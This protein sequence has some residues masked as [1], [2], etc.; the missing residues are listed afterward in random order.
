MLEP[1]RPVERDLPAG[2]SHHYQFEMVAGQ[3]ARA[4]LDKTSGDFVLI[5]TGS[6]GRNIAE[7]KGAQPQEP[8]GVVWVAKAS[9][10]H[11]LEVRSLAKEGP[12]ARYKLSIEE[13]RV[14]TEQDHSHV[15][16]AKAY[17][18]A[19]RLRLEGTPQSL[20]QSIGKYEEA[21]PLYRAAGKRQDEA[22]TLA[23]VGHVRA[24]LGEHR[25][26]LDYYQ[27]SLPLYRE[28]GD[29]SGEANALISIANIS[30]AQ[31]DYR[32]ALEFHNQALPLH[33]Q[34][35][36]RRGEAAALNN[37]ARAYVSLE[38]YAKALDFHRQAF[39]VYRALDDGR[40]Q[41]SALSSAGAIHTLRGEYSQALDSY[42]QALALY[43][44]LGDRRG[45]AVAL[46]LL[47]QVY[48]SL[49][50]YQK[51]LDFH[52]QALALHRAA[53]DRNGEAGALH[54]LGAVYVS[55]GEYRQALDSFNQALAL[56]RAA[57]NRRSEAST[58]N[59][60]AAVH[61]VMDEH[62][63][64]LDVYQ[65]A[66][67]L[68]RAAG[69][70]RGEAAALNNIGRTYFSL[71][72][73]PKSLDFHQQALGLI[74]AAGD[75]RG[76][77][78]MRYN[79]A[80]AQRARGDLAAA[81]SQVEEAIRLVESLRHEVSVQE[82]RASLFASVRNFF[83]LEIDLLMQQH[84]QKPSGEF[85][86]A[87]LETSERARARGLLELLAEARVDLRQ[88]ADPAL[89]ER[90]RELQRSLDDKAERQTQLLSG[91]H[92][93]E[94]AA[95]AAKEVES[96]LTEYQQV[97]AQIRAGSPRYAA[98]TQP[99]LLSAK[100]IQQQVPEGDTLLLEYALGEE[101]SYLWAVT[102]DSITSHELPKRAEIEAAARKFYEL[103][104]KAEA[105]NAQAAAA[106]A[107]LSRMLL[108]PVADRLQSKRLVIVPDGVLHYIP[109][110]SLPKPGAGN[111]GAG[112]KEK[113]N[114]PPAPNPR[115]LIVDHEVVTLPS[116]SVLAELRRD[117]SGRK[118]APGAVAVFA[119]PV[120]SRDDPRL[121][122]G[123][124]TPETETQ[125]LAS[126]LERSIRDVGLSGGGA[127][128]PRLPFSR[129]EAEAIIAVAP[130][131]QWAR[132][133]DFQ[134]SRT[135]A[136]ND[137]LGNY[138][139]IHF[140]THGLLNSRHPELSG[141][142]L[143]LVDRQGQPQNGFLRFHEIYNLK[144]PAELVVL[145]ACQTGLGKEIRGEGLVGL[146]R[147]FMYAG[148]ARVAASL[149]KVDD[150][151]TAELMKRFY[152]GM[153]DKRL[154]PAAA[155]REAQIGMWRQERWRAPYFWAAFVIQG[156]WK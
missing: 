67:P 139:I 73:Y 25:R 68:A 130:Q 70:R 93:P 52:Q 109:F 99:K 57:G 154:R 100:E 128:F 102:H 131:R 92:T 98:L 58:L 106:A 110:A 66:L 90:E 29:R 77:A 147:A 28:I 20:R 15:A 141:I 133:L 150:A 35:G 6:E 46:N 149:W 134:A 64:A 123:N 105:E 104:K 43:R 143:S 10:A 54:N 51:S 78:Q 72:E 59:G 112:T 125:P 118:P 86:A 1:G 47:G 3:Y 17:T 148:A 132:S 111:W 140:A 153:F 32:K 108:A 76:E 16:A 31:R 19:T 87:A 155:L 79:L 138:R 36:D 107:D 39:S 96:L 145:S 45:E 14:A 97:Q 151:A 50:D 13:L 83:E 62:Q 117:L 56:L 24:Q 22:H 61:T 101:R 48:K 41:A 136:T 88:G 2:Q 120:F 129:R 126:D 5:V 81:R 30:S 44:A 38:D 103:A 80:R 33:R 26:A 74:R 89:L 114:Q 124:R 21:L 27:Q 65:Q 55:L 53:G 135:A 42:H 60:I 142:V 82:Q 9:G 49:G 115:P 75:R 34:A 122:S 18:E 71:G 156:E 127:G 85:V 91:R 8:L 144:L 69:N 84:K 137:D 63:K 119:D 121:K 40:G 95:A 146:T 116:A 94:Q 23:T 12:P 7:A 113:N 11:R 4:V 152:R 37:I